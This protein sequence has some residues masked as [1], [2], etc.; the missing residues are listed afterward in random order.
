M[1]G[2]RSD[3]TKKTMVAVP[4]PEDALEMQPSNPAAAAAEQQLAGLATIETIKKSWNLRSI[5]L[6]WIGAA[7]VSF[8]VSYD[9]QTYSTYQP[10]A[11]SEFGSLSLLSTIAVVQN[12][13]S[14]IQQPVAKLADVYGRLPLLVACVVIVTIG[15]ILLA[16][17]KNIQ[18]FA[19]AQVFFTVGVVGLHLLLVILAGDSSD[20]R[21]RALMNVVPYAPGLITAWTASYVT[22]AVLKDTSWRWGYGV[23]AIIVPIISIPLLATL[24]YHQRKAR[25]QYPVETGPSLGLKHHC[26]VIQQLDPIGLILFCAGMAL[27]LVPITLASTSTNT[28]K[29]GHI[30]AM[31]VVGVVC[32]VGFVLWEWK[33]AQ[34][35]VIPLTILKGRTGSFGIIAAILDY[36][37][38]Y[39]TSPYLYTYLLVVR[40]LS[41]KAATNISII[42]PFTAV[43]GQLG[44]GVVAKYAGRYKWITAAGIGLKVL[45]LGLMLRYRHADSSLGSF[46]VAQVLQG[47]GEGIFNTVIAGMQGAVSESLLASIVALFVS[48]CGVGG[49]IGAAVAGGIWTNVLPRQLHTNLPASLQAQLAEIYGSVVVAI[50]FPWGT[51]ERNDIN[52]S[53]DATM[54]ILII[55]ALVLASLEFLAVLMLQDFNLKVVDQGRDY[56]GAVI[57]KTTAKAAAVP[58]TD[59]DGMAKLDHTDTP[60]EQFDVDR[61]T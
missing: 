10:Y 20:L 27:I 31:I 57:G 60:L 29:S 33:W 43:L 23:F 22:S 3:D 26:L 54:R 16:S 24:Y 37:S 25:K 1:T 35:P 49:A 40:N 8:A 39:T 36:A 4:V 61:E 41:V 53:Y 50:Q 11:T 47:L 46:A 45:G 5:V 38:W 18:T 44:A 7:L 21:H 12:V 13:V 56:G 59:F 14:I 30:I 19:G 15:E 42:I 58:P 34:W 48:S 28:W 17:A 6:T 55:V 32:F 9:Q 51:T 52:R 2:T